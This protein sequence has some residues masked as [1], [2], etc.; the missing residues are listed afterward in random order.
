VVQQISHRDQLIYKRETYLLLAEWERQENARLRAWLDDYGQLLW[1]FEE[2]SSKVELARSDVLAI[3][4]LN[5][6]AR[7][8]QKRIAEFYGIS[9]STV[10]NITRKVG[11]FHE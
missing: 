2:T 4:Q 5:A 8:S 3:R 7:F 10:G 1:A 11:R 6:T 9:T